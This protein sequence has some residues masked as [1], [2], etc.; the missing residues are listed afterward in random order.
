MIKKLL[1]IIYISSKNA[2]NIEKEEDIY[3]RI[4]KINQIISFEKIKND[5]PATYDESIKIYKIFL[6]D[7]HFRQETE[8]KLY[9]DFFKQS[10]KNYDYVKNETDLDSNYFHFKATVTSTEH[11]DKKIEFY[12]LSETVPSGLT[13]DCEREKINCYLKDEDIDIPYITI[14]SDYNVT[15]HLLKDSLTGGFKNK[16]L[17]YKNKYLDLKKK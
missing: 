12:F 5:H 11:T 14:V 13:G 15:S 16:Y 4:D 3:N 7:D 10:L 2:F 1:I 8:V 6:F 9:L 17:K